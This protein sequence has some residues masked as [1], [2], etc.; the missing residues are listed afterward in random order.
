MAVA[1]A[2]M[3]APRLSLDGEW[4][5]SI[6]TLKIGVDRQWFTDTLNRNSWM[7]VRTP[8]YWETYPGLSAFD[9]WGWFYRTFEMG[10][11]S[12]QMA[13]H[14]AGV[15]DDATVWINGTMVGEHAG[16][17]DPFSLDVSRALHRGVNSIAVQVK[18]YA[19]GGGIFKPVTLIA[20]RALDELEKSPYYGTA[21][22]KSAD[23]V[24]DATIYSVYLRSASPEGTFAGFEKRLKEVR[25][26]GVNVLWFLPIHPVGV[27]ARKGSL[28]SPYAVRD[29][30]GINPEFGTLDDFKRLLASAHSL[31]MKVI[32]DLVANHTSWDS[33]LITQHPEWFTHDAHGTIVPPNTDWTDVADLDYSQPALRRYMIG[34]MRWWVKDV[35]IDGFRCDVAELVPTD[36]WEE[37]R[38]QL[39]RIKPVMMLSEGSIPEHHVKAFDLTY[40]WN[41]YDILTPLLEG[42]KPVTLLDAVLRN[43]RLRYPTGSL[44]MRFTTN[45]DKNAWD[46][47]AVKKFG[48][49]GLRLATILVNTLPGVPM[50]YTG[51]EVE[52]DRTLSLFEK[53]PVD[54][55]R[56][57]AMGDLWKKLFMLRGEHKSLSRGEMV[58][59]AVSPDSSVYAFVRAA[60]KDRTIVILNFSSSP[61]HVS[62]RFPMDLL[63]PGRTSAM[64]KDVFTGT[65]L[66]LDA[67]GVADLTLPPRASWLLFPDA[68][69]TK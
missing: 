7:T 37:A 5:F 14:F 20:A 11:V 59:I 62:L 32:I 18:D 57:H 67:Q 42:T 10:S 63:F 39:N 40:A 35:G 2:Q 66:A 46:A 43:E 29:F 27:K 69:K 56:S 17:T 38:A 16:W 25:D 64:L 1:Q 30:E 51:E 3:P 52:N 60:G 6:D 68:K 53:V 61:E 22:L 28:G 19:G 54:W 45:H 9:G 4:L 15:D 26:L 33:K 55:H 44:R 8:A 24:K 13:I 50:L 47:P 58:R 49:D 31:G 48:H 12:E 21:A 65:T 23:W 41:V 34:M 36:F